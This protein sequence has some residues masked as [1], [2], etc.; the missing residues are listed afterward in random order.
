MQIA[1]LLLEHGAH[2]WFFDSRN[3]ERDTNQCDFFIFKIKKIFTYPIQVNWIGAA[4]NQT[5]T[6]VIDGTFIWQFFTF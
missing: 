1:K 5:E 6:V 3:T 2:Q 4:H